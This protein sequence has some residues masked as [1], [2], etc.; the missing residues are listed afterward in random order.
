MKKT[1]LSTI[2][3]VAFLAGAGDVSAGIRTNRSETRK[4]FAVYSGYDLVSKMRSLETSFELFKKVAKDKSVKT[5]CSKAKE[6]ANKIREMYSL[7]SHT[8]SL[9]RFNKSVTD[10][11]KKAINALAETNTEAKKAKENILTISQEVKSRPNGNAV[12]NQICDA[13]IDVFGYGSTTPAVTPVVASTQTPASTTTSVPATTPAQTTTTAPSPAASSTGAS[14]ST[15]NASNSSAKSTTT[16][17]SSTLF[18]VN[19][20]T[21]SNASSGLRSKLW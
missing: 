10:E 18:R 9:N 16:T 12:V 14:S 19:S 15:N 21:S 7:S 5:I 1:I 3:A 2:L 11:V 8:R 6:M 20:S 4:A 13:I 17:P